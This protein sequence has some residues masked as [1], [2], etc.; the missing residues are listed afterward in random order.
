MVIEKGKTFEGSDHA[1][2]ARQQATPPQLF[3]S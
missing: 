2:F 3:A 1:G